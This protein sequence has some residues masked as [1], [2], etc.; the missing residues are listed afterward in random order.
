[1]NDFLCAPTTLKLFLASA[2]CFLKCPVLVIGPAFAYLAVSV[3]GLLLRQPSILRAPNGPQYPSSPSPLELTTTYRL[4]M[5]RTYE[6]GK[7]AQ[8]LLMTEFDKN[9]IET[10]EADSDVCN[11]EQNSIHNYETP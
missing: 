9:V 3:V 2:W 10:R 1:M 7:A 5:E 8:R 11:E 4:S 6:G